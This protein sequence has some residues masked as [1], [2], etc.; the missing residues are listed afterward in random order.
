MRGRFRGEGEAGPGTA[1]LD[2]G[3]GWVS[4][5]AWGTVLRGRG[6]GVNEV[7]RGLGG[8]LEDGGKLAGAGVSQERQGHSL[9]AWGMAVRGQG[10]KGAELEMA[11]HP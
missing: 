10:G 4:V 5:R 9:R 6:W 8:V 11:G 1:R 2:T 7:R 3:Q